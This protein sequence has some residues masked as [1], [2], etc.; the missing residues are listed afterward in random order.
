MSMRRL[1]PACVALLV[2]AVFWA[3]SRFTSASLVLAMDLAELTRRADRVLVGEVLVVHSDWD[4]A[5]R[6]ILTTVEVQVSEMWKGEAPRH[7]RIV[8]V[9]PGGTV[10]DIEMRVHGLP[11]FTPGERSVLFLRGQHH[12]Q[13]VGL[14]QGRRLLRFDTARRMWMVQGGDRSAAVIRDPSGRLQAAPPEQALP[15]DELRRRVQALVKP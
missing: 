8:I 12:A 6:R 5:R 14:G 4:Q 15:L 7:G 1:F 3:P 2:A 11:R 9:Q 10:G 13:V